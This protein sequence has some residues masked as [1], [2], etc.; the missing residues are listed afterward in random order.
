MQ[1]FSHI[2]HSSVGSTEY[3]TF[4][5]S[6]GEL[7][8]FQEYGQPGKRVI[9]LIHGFTGSSQYFERNFNTLSQKYWV[10]APDIRGHGR[11]TKSRHGY[12][13]ARLAAD[14]KDLIDIIF[15]AV[16]DARIAGTGCSLG[17]AV[18]WTYAELF[19]SAVFSSM[20]FV[21]Q[22]PLQDYIPGSWSFTHGNYGVHDAT[23]LA[24]AQAT[25]HYEPDEFYRGLVQGC[26]GYRYQPNSYETRNIP[27]SRQQA[28]EELFI[29]ISRQGDPWWFSKLLAN[30][31]SYDHRDTI[32]NLIRCPCLI[33]AGSR[34]GSFPVQGIFETAKLINDGA[35][36]QLA[37]TVEM[38]SGHWMFFEHHIQWTGLVLDFLDTT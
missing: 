32:R 15:A 20:I 10:I 2:A 25:L 27:S 9:I 3:K 17:A 35:G 14:L 26:L 30:H 6:D 16:P 1:S 37:K 4:K 22:A 34:S 36:Q 33:M 38:D 29:N 5:A 7:L 8:S 31:T 21:D 11:S 23:S 24:A 28:E 19:S 12:H 18:L 13:V